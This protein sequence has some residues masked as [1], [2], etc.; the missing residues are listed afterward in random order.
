MGAGATTSSVEALD[1]E[2][3]LSV[4]AADVPR[5]RALLA[6]AERAQR[7]LWLS[8]EMGWWWC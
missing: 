1:D 6:L 2:Q 3:L 5:A 4:L 7:L 8:Q